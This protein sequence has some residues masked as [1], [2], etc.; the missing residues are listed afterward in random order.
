LGYLLCFSAVVLWGLTQ[1]PIKLAKT[2]GRVG[3]MISVPSALAAL[4]V[5]L[6]VQGKLVIPHASHRDW[7]FIALAGVTNFSLANFGYL[8]AVQRAGITVAAP[9]SRL[10]PVIVVLAQAVITG[11]T[12]SPW[13]TT[14]AT[15]IF[16][17]GALCG[18]GARLVHPV[19]HHGNL[20]LGMVLAVFACLMWAGGYLALGQISSE[21]PRSLV[22]FYGLAFGAAAYWII[23]MLAGRL[24]AL[25][26]VTP[27]DVAL[28]A[29][30]GVVSYTL[31][32]WAMFEGIR[33][34]GVSEGTVIA[35]SWPAAAVIVGVVVLHE[36]M[37][38][39]KFVGA[40]LMVASAAAVVL[41]S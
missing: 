3:V 29:V 24:E 21:V 25:K 9:I 30:H 27:R 2:P 10:T 17:G 5:I 23:V 31:A 19:E 38:A 6:A 41:L 22:T 16:I 26:T 39:Q 32:Y 14:V 35:E 28:Y 33:I 34:L 8:E 7:I 40:A 20:H 11:T 36:R 12:L 18:R 4:A 13:L 1:I 37:N 15:L